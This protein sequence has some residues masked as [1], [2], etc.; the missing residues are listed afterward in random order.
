MGKIT[1]RNIGIHQL[2]RLAKRL[3]VTAG[4]ALTTCLLVMVTAPGIASEPTDGIIS[5]TS[6]A[7]LLSEGK[8]A[9]HAG[10]LTVASQHWQSAAQLYEAQ[11]DQVD[12]ALSLSY[13]SLSYQELGNWESA[14][15]AGQ[16][17]LRLLQNRHDL[18]ERGQQVLAQVLN[19]YGG[20]QLAMGQAEEA[21]A[22]WQKAARHYG[23]LGD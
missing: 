15:R 13:L 11:S 20:L 22:T 6:A 8:I 2:W 16:Q 12:Q 10:Q 5:N 1:R 21:L 7:T 23:Q 4:I 9:H 18:D 19:T 3:S 14:K 17:S